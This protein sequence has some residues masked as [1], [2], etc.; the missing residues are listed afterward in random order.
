MV[1]SCL[2]GSVLTV[3]LK[4]SLSTSSQL[5][6]AAAGQ[7]IENAALDLDKIDCDNVAVLLGHA[8]GCSLE[9]T[10][11]SLQQFSSSRLA[12]LSPFQILKAWPN[13]HLTFYRWA[14]GDPQLTQRSPR[15]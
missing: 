5:A 10:E 6:V 11:K 13:K 12:R 8:G 9:E 15:Y 7:A 1:I 4:A 3:A 14:Q 2:S